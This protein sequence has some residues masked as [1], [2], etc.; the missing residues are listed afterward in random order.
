MTQIV[1]VRAGTRLKVSWLTPDGHLTLG[2]QYRKIGLNQVHED[3]CGKRKGIP[4][5]GSLDVPNI[6]AQRKCLVSLDELLVCKAREACTVLLLTHLTY[7][8][9]TCFGGKTFLICIGST[10]KNLRF[11]GRPMGEER[12]LA[13]GPGSAVSSWGPPFF[14]YLSA[15][16][17]NDIDVWNLRPGHVFWD[18]LK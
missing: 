1:V 2:E 17:Y 9:I 6:S 16:S 12:R 4:A 15:D 8:D 18:P 10:P 5:T 13:P 14:T 3:G 11:M 7:P